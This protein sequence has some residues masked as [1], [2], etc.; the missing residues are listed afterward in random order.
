MDNQQQQPQQPIQTSSYPLE[1]PSAHTSYHFI[2]FVRIF[3]FILII[4]GLGLLFTEKYWL[5]PLVNKILEYQNVPVVSEVPQVPDQFADWKTYRDDQYG[6]EIKYPP[7]IGVQNL[8][9]LLPNKLKSI[10]F[11]T[12]YISDYSSV[13]I[14]VFS[15]PNDLSPDNFYKSVLQGH[16]F[17]GG[18]KEYPYGTDKIEDID[19]GGV[20]GIKVTTDWFLDTEIRVFVAK[21]NIML[22]FYSSY[23]TTDD[24]KVKKDI[25]N[26]FN[27]ILSTFKFINPT[28]NSTVDNRIL[29]TEENIPVYANYASS[30]DHSACSENFNYDPENSTTTYSNSKWGLSFEV[31]FNSNWG[32]SKYKLNP[33]E[34][35]AH[36]PDWVGVQAEISY[37]YISEGESCSWIRNGTVYVVDKN[38]SDG[39]FP[40]T[41]NK[42]SKNINGLQVMK[43][44]QNGLCDYSTIR[45]SGKKYDYEFTSACNSGFIDIEKIVNTVKL[46]N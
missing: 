12:N 25:E 37:G 39:D 24:D 31:P 44:D 30:S 1:Y 21:G 4:I 19:V 15:N 9:W 33:Y 22:G 7:E 14:V 29:L 11:G 34:E 27:K 28:A 35:V 5:S 38:Y 41:E 43:F 20:K 6:Y 23:S 45:V 17:T 40:I 42:I 18:T 46:I 10:Y 8:D 32:N 36:K 2:K 13:D 26:S 16:E 3:L